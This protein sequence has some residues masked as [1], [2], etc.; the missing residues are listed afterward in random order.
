MSEVKTEVC[1]FK[2]DLGKNLYRKKTYY[3]IEIQQEVLAD[4][5]DEA[6]QKFLDG[7][8]INYSEINTLNGSI[9]ENNNGVETNYV[10]CN[11]SESGS[12]EYVGKVVYDPDDEYAK[13]DGFVIVDNLVDENEVLT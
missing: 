4:N 12:T 1:V 7:G 6:D 3:T 13:E 11:Y 5:K 10:D 2:D 8:G 9:T